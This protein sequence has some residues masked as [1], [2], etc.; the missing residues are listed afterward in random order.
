M[1]CGSYCTVFIVLI[2]CVVTLGSSFFPFTSDVPLYLRN[3]VTQVR[4]DAITE[5]EDQADYTL[6]LPPLQLRSS[7]DTLG[8]DRADLTL[9]IIY[10]PKYGDV[11][12][13]NI[14]EKIRDFE[15][16]VR[17]RA[18]FDQWCLITYSSEELSKQ[19]SGDTEAVKAINN[20]S[21][22]CAVHNTILWACDQTKGIPC[23]DL[24]STPVGL[25][26]CNKTEA[27][28]SQSE[29]FVDPV[30]KV[31]KANVYA[32]SI[33]DRNTVKGLNSW[34]FLKLIDSQFGPGHQIA[35]AVRTEFLFGV[36]F[37]GYT[38]VNDDPDGQSDDLATYLYNN[39]HSWLLHD[40]IHSDVDYVFNG[41]GMFEKYLKATLVTDGM[42]ALASMIFVLTYIAFM[43]SSWW[44]ALMGMGQIMLS[45]GPAYFIYYGIFQ[46][47]FF[48]VFNMLS[49]F[50]ILGVGAD[51]IFVFL[52]T[53]EQSSHKFKGLGK[54]MAWT[55]KHAGKAM[56]VTSLST[57][58][59]FIS[60]ANSEFP[61]I[62]T[63]GLFAAMLVLVNY[64]AVMIYFPT[65]VLVY[66]THFEDFKF[67]FGVPEYLSEKINKGFEM[68]TVSMADFKKVKDEDGTERFTYT[69]PNESRINKWFRES[70]S[71]GI[72]HAKI[73]ILIT[74]IAVIVFFV[75]EAS[76]LEPDP[77][78]PQMLPRSDNYQSFIDKKPEYFARGGSVNAVKV[79]FAWG[80]DKK[81]PIDRSGVPATDTKNLGKPVWDP[82]FSLSKA[83]RCINHICETAQMKSDERK[84]GG[85]PDFPIDCFMMAF[86]QW[87]VATNGSVLWDTI[88]GPNAD[89]KLFQETFLSWAADP[90]VMST[91]KKYVYGE[92]VDGVGV[93]RFVTAELK[94]TVTTTMD[95]DEGVGL[96]NTWEDW[97]NTQYNLSPCRDV[98]VNASGFQSSF[99]F[100]FIRKSLVDEAMSGIR[101]S[102][103]LAFAV[104]AIATFNIIVAF[105]ATAII[106]AIV[107]CTMGTV[108]L[109][110]WKLGVL[111]SI[112]LVMVPGLSVDYVAHLAEAYVG[113]SSPDRVSRVR[114]ML[115]R[116]AIS[117]VSG[118]VSTLGA[119]VFLFLPTIVF[120]NKFGIMMFTT[121]GFSLVWALIFFPAL[122]AT[123]LGP[124]GNIGNWWYLAC[125]IKKKLSKKK[126]A[127]S[128]ASGGDHNEPVE[129]I[130]VKEDEGK[131]ASV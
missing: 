19:D 129:M 25:L 85:Y 38:T 9:E 43:T 97:F 72:M 123:P 101:L 106:T 103:S 71:S 86:K 11:L 81:H 98:A 75:I 61:A 18:N 89:D 87:V 84:T 122:M 70:Y 88:T 69:E 79:T 45:F 3:H 13:S 131:H 7:V 114:D 102:I 40:Q 16:R 35:K 51:D 22:P 8:G 108:V 94:L 4:E 128:P 23:I 110:G 125:L 109:L 76:R 58:F 57:M 2:I 21:Y 20:Q 80:F 14:L 53:W 93:L 115:A 17:T 74:F 82:N 47:R 30:F 46:Q 96:W 12:E 50:I 130:D 90:A 83:A 10:L 67:C 5:G 62:Q 119:C 100:A 39:F 34:N 127:P 66:A 24:A 113:S 63:F 91:W 55:W 73:C 48:G 52:D 95:A 44:F 120:F 32:N 104:L 92:E 56:L 99:V 116:V 111:E 59:S 117:I 41:H 42:Y 31:A 26:T 36:P 64:C 60:N 124:Q 118:S 15:A 27:C 6:N 105:Y 112:G 77:D 65:V 28:T 68:V 126:I 49:I 37:K 29:M 121:I 1:T 33:P 78:P 107:M 54:R